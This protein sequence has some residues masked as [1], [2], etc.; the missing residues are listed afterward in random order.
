MS[1][2]P[3][4]PLLVDI[5]D[6]PA[7]AANSA[8]RAQSPDLHAALAI[9]ATFLVDELIDEFLPLIEA[10]LRERLEARLREL[11]QAAARER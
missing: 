6:L 1:D 3:D 10:R 2:E 7:A 8:A 5:V 9:E 4:I 11:A